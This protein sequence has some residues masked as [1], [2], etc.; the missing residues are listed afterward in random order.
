MRTKL[1]ERK[2]ALS[3]VSLL[4]GMVLLFKTTV[5]YAPVSVSEKGVVL[6]LVGLIAI[7]FGFYL[8]KKLSS[9]V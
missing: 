5:I 8:V 1:S 9:K 2:L 3:I 6:T 4:A 7:A